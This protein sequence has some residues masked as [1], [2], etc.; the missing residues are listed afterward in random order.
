[1]LTPRAEHRPKLLSY[2]VKNPEKTPSTSKKPSCSRNMARG[3]TEYIMNEDEELKAH[4]NFPQ[5]ESYLEPLPIFSQP[6]PLRSDRKRVTPPFD[7]VES[8][9]LTGEIGP[10]PSASSITNSGD[11]PSNL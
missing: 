6:T 4:E 5:T 9:D 3:T 2:S 11:Q 1:M 8:I 7:T 10:L